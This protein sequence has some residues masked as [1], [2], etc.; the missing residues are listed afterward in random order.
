MKRIFFFN[1]KE[2]YGMNQYKIAK[3][4]LIL[5]VL[6][7]FAQIFFKEPQQYKPPPI[8]GGH[9]PSVQVNSRYNVYSMSRHLKSLQVTTQLNSHMILQVGNTHYAKFDGHTLCESVYV[10]MKTAINFYDMTTLLYFVIKEKFEQ[11]WV[12]GSYFV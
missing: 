4:D 8:Y 12:I 3:Y 7:L 9:V 5:T 2:A 10:T 11:M 6:I 1:G